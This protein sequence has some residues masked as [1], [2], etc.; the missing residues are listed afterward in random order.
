MAR[1]RGSPGIAERVEAFRANLVVETHTLD[2]A[3]VQSTL[4]FA[5]E[6]A[7]VLVAS[8]LQCGRRAV[9]EHLVAAPPAGLE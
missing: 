8:R 4:A 3:S 9:L 5:D 6:A 1:P 2:L 7:P